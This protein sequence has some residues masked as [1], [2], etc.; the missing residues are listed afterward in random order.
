[1]RKTLEIKQG[2]KV[3]CKNSRDSE[4][5]TQDSDTVL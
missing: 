2:S 5:R 1:M 3:T 4:Q